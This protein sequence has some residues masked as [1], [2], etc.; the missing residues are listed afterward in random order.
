MPSTS[1]VTVAILALLACLFVFR[2][3]AVL[4]DSSP[5]VSV[6]IE[7]FNVSGE[8]RVRLR[9]LL[10]CWAEEGTWVRRGDASPHV[11]WTPG[12]R[13]GDGEMESRCGPVESRGEAVRYQWVPSPS[14]AVAT[15][16]WNRTV[17]AEVLGPPP[18]GIEAVGDSVSGEFASTLRAA[19][20]CG[21]PSGIAVG[22]QRNDRLSMGPT[23]KDDARNF[24]D[25]AFYPLGRHVRAVVLN[26]GAHY[27]ETP[28]V[29]EAVDALVTALWRDRPDLL[30]VYRS[31]APGHPGCGGHQHDAPLRPSDLPLAQTNQTQAYHWAD[32]PA[33]NDAVRRLLETRHPHVLFLDV[34]PMTA[35]RRDSHWSTHDCLHYCSPGPIDAWV[36]AFGRLLYALREAAHGRLS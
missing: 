21:H 1:R 28:R 6:R 27:E 22:H 4:P 23:V 24:F 8:Q 16:D 32:L 31:T 12:A 30:V 35:L 10:A 33:Q 34:A 5:L 19:L 11:L 29:L 13:C 20:D 2:L 17:V 26:R 36:E 9:R 18:V 3:F 15:P 14:C 7:P 25:Y